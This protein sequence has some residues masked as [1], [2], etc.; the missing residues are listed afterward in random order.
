MIS[1]QMM[2]K[3]S[4]SIWSATNGMMP[5]YADCRFDVKG[6]HSQKARRGGRYRDSQDD[7]H[8]VG[9]HGLAASA[10]RNGR[11]EAITPSTRAP[12]IAARKIT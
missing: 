1:G 8:V 3:V 2:Q 7:G 4:V 10:R 5:R 11:G 9:R 6:H 12:A